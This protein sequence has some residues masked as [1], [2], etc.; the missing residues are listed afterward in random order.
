MTGT[1][2]YGLYLDFQITQVPVYIERGTVRYCS[3]Y[4]RALL[5]RPGLVRRVA[6][7][8]MMPFP[9]GLNQELLAHS[10]LEW[11]TASNFRKAEQE[12]PTAY[13]VMTPFMLSQFDSLVPPH[14]LRP[15]IPLVMTLT[16][17]FPVSHPDEFFLRPDMA[18]RLAVRTGLIKSADLV[19]TISQ[20]TR[21]EAIRC[22]GLDPGKVVAVGTGISSYFRPAP[23]PEVPRRLVAGALKSIDKPFVLCVTGPWP[24]KNTEA[25]IRAF[26]KLPATLREEHQLVL[27]CRLTE[28][29]RAGW[30]EHAR[31]CGL[32]PDQVIQTDLVTEPV[33]RALYQSAKL[34]VYPPLLEGFGLPAAEAAACGCPTLVSNTS[35]M[36][37]VLNMPA[38]TFP[39]ED[40]DRMAD[41]MVRGLTDEA[42]RTELK[43][44]AA[45][46]AKTHTW[47][48]VVDRTVDAM[49]SLESPSTGQPEASVRPRVA[50]VGSLPQLQKDN[51]Q[52]GRHLAWRLSGLCH[53][54]LFGSEEPE[55][56][57][58]LKPRG[59]RAFSPAALG[60][61]IN[62]AGYDA[63]IYTFG[64][65]PE[66]VRKAANDTA[67]LFPGIVWL[68][69][70]ALDERPGICVS[71]LVLKL[72]RGIIVT[73]AEQLRSLKVQAGPLTELAPAAV[74]HKPTDIV[75]FVRS[76][77][78][79]PAAK[80]AAEASASQPVPAG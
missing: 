75:R 44:A 34:F 37:E 3:D 45:W 48:N 24:R 47:D 9:A 51:P 41:L 8:P 79:E 67:L 11:S 14:A 7:N 28:E 31:M 12:G 49:G 46:S 5:K 64:Y 74:V 38:A 18:K 70:S 30:T 42:F 29:V 17:V 20:A 54:D 15:D 23:D 39:P 26:A 77:Q 73:R 58:E 59:V 16:D 66:E 10:R 35:S 68:Q 33:L 43:A 53:L 61:H 76:L 63:I 21:S 65:E 52:S 32:R 4:A 1:S 6:L 56:E 2:E 22:L 27:T 40:T 50:L 69:P 78:G 55:V 62:P 36:P 80:P 13:H 60:R 71:P 72:A 57:R 25:L 19:L